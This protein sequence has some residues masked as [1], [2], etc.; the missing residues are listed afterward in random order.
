MQTVCLL[1]LVVVAAAP[2]TL[3]GAWVTPSISAATSK[4]SVAFTT[5]TNNMHQSRSIRTPEGFVLSA[6]FDDEED[7]SNTATDEP[8]KGGNPDYPDL[9]ELKGDFDW[10]QKFRGDDDWIVEDVPGKVVLNEIELAEQATKLG[11]LE[12][13]W[14]RDREISEYEDS[15]KIGF[16]EGAE[17]LNGR[18]A[19][20]FLVTGL[21]TEYWTGISMPGQ[22]EEMLR[23]GGIIGFD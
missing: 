13:K 22:V 17:K 23:I 5:K 9:P 19:M 4:N 1:I 7:D 10:D 16:V 20:F 18:A 8:K 3:V 6:S 15:A 21:L 12:D 11:K 14:R 2:G